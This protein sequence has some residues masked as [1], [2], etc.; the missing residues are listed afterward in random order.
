MS[1]IDPRYIR[2]L[3]QA[4]LKPNLD[5]LSAAASES[6]DGADFADI[7]NTIM[8][9]VSDDR[10]A[11]PSYASTQAA[12]NA[13][14][15]ATTAATATPANSAYK[16][17][18]LMQL[19]SLYPQQVNSAAGST[20]YD[21]IVEQAARQYGIDAKLIHSV[22]GAESGYRSNVVSAAGAK[23]LMQL[24]D[25]TARQMGVADSF[26][27]AQNIFGGTRYLAGLLDRYDGN[28]A[29]ALAAY[30]AGPARVEALKV[31]ND[32]EL[33]AKITQLPLE[34]QKYVAAVMAGRSSVS[35]IGQT[36]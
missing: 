26:D 36:D 19:S 27:P 25:G 23:G 35:R 10:S 13:A 20:S 15:R 29:M 6:D 33:M 12:E 9:G 4:Q 1:S 30:N 24:M 34:T 21:S 5:G 28:E 3:L 32:S 17:W 8:M 2:Q 22:I 7:L 11:A 31:R 14:G 18:N 16:A